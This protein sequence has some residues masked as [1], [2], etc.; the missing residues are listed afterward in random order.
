MNPKKAQK[1]NK[2]ENNQALM[3]VHNS[4]IEL[5][6][7]VKVRSNEEIVNLNDDQLERE[8]QKLL[9]V[10]TLSLI[11]YIKTSIEILLNL[12]METSMSANNYSNNKKRTSGNNRINTDTSNQLDNSQLTNNSNYT[13]TTNGQK[14]PPKAYE[15][16]IQKLENDIRNHIRVEQQMK[17]AM[18]ALQ[19]KIEDKDRE[20]AKLRQEY[21]LYVQE[22]KLDKKRYIELLELRDQEMTQLND[23]LKKYD[24]MERDYQTQL[25]KIGTQLE[26]FKTRERSNSNN[27]E[28]VTHQN[29]LSRS[30]ERPSIQYTTS[31]A[32]IVINSHNNQ[33]S[34]T[35]LKKGSSSGNLA[36][37]MN[38]SG[39]VRKNSLNNNSNSNNNNNTNSRKSPDRQT[40][41]IAQSLNQSSKVKTLANSNNSSQIKINMIDALKN[42]DLGAKKQ[43]FLSTNNNSNNPSISKFQGSS[44]LVG[45]HRKSNSSNMSST[46]NL[47]SLKGLA[48]QKSKKSLDRQQNSQK[49][50]QQQNYNKYAVP[51]QSVVVQINP[52]QSAFN[53]LQQQNNSRQQNLMS[54]N[55]M[56][57]TTQQ[58][59]YSI[60]SAAGKINQNNA[61]KDEYDSHLLIGND[62]SFG[63]TTHNYCNQ[64]QDTD[65]GEN[66]HIQQV[67][68]LNQN[69][70]N[71]PHHK[72]RANSSGNASSYSLNNTTRMRSKENQNNQ[73]TKL[74]SSKRQAAGT[75]LQCHVNPTNDSNKLSSTLN[76]DLS[77]IQKGSIQ[78][79][80][81][82]K[83]QRVLNQSSSQ[84]N[85]GNDNRPASA[86]TQ[87][88]YTKLFLTQ[89]K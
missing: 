86:A 79:P 37:G 73:G 51:T 58:S 43:S 28:C 11:E 57:Q 68:P 81:N 15:E 39:F 53:N 60:L 31:R 13:S 34:Q 26:E 67:L 12:K 9:E 25:K 21:K 16:I 55:Q 65:I 19:Q 75:Q 7:D 61:V 52:H 29:N 48:S 10:D 47:T 8:Q 41:L 83:D 62:E 30:L 22:L 77:N 20:R 71:I 64:I 2:F 1:I 82:Y 78:Q 72:S 33:N 45:G 49:Q 74:I 63:N 80:S 36:L 40:I 27:N 4:L 89:R 56:P 76:V 46:Q 17:I 32:S 3:E 88:L 24:N 42:R 66:N 50:A 23:R 59:S 84:N 6:L 38:Q 35:F 18:E 54:K 69:L 44:E 85:L 87:S 70:E 14:E 5:Y